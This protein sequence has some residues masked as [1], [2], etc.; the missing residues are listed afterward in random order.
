MKPNPA[1]QVLKARIRVLEL[2]KQRLLVEPREAVIPRRQIPDKELNAAFSRVCSPHGV[3]PA[4]EN[5]LAILCD[6]FTQSAPAAQSPSIIGCT[7]DFDRRVI[8]FPAGTNL[9]FSGGARIVGKCSV[10]RTPS[11]A[12]R[13]GSKAPEPDGS[14]MFG[15]I[16]A[17]L[18]APSSLRRK[19]SRRRSSGTP[20]LRRE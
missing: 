4:L 18:R 12:D 20:E 8:E 17:K 9:L 7:I 6:W 15:N 19:G 5:A 16:A 2:E 3:V 1:I 14:L 10:N 13:L 11:E